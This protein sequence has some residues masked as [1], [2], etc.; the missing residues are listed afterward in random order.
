MKSR[1]LKAVLAAVSALAVLATAMTGFAATITTT[2]TYDDTDKVE[3]TAVVAD[4]NGSEITYLVET[5]G[6]GVA[7]GIVYIDQQTAD[8]GAATF[9]YKVDKAKIGNYAMN[10]TMGSNGEDTFSGQA[11]ALTAGAT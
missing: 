4:A 8:N 2:T 7:D 9:T 10:V 6:T 5:D 1:K 3:V 11:I